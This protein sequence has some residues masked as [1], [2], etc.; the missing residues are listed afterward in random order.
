MHDMTLED[1]RA[2]EASPH[3]ASAEELFQLGLNY[4]LGAG[5]MADL[6]TAQKWLSLAALK[7]SIAARICRR[8]L[9]E[10]MTPSDIAEAQRQAGSWIRPH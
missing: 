9:A 3:A 7:G 5:C 8:V 4:S 10:E 1:A 6:V 2:A